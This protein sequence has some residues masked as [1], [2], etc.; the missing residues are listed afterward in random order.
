MPLRG[1]ARAVEGVG[2]VA[3]VIGVDDEFAGV[4]RIRVGWRV[5]D[6]EGDGGTREEGGLARL[7]DASIGTRAGID[8]EFL[9]LQG[10]PEQSELWNQKPVRGK[11]PPWP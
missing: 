7:R 10:M 8:P 1:A 6:R 5:V 2:R 4:A 9:F 3:A 11:V